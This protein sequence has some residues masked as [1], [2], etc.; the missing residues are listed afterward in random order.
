M[1]STISGSYGEDGGG[2]LIVP[3]NYLIILLNKTLCTGYLPKNDI[4]AKEVAVILSVDILESISSEISDLICWQSDSAYTSFG[5]Y[6]G[7]ISSD[8]DLEQMAKNINRLL[9]ISFFILRLQS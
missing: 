1:F 2:G 5:S 7:V 6:L 8:Q 3:I 4:Q 9:S